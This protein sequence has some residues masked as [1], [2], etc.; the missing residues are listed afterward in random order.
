MVYTLSFSKIALKELGKINEPFY[1]NIKQAILNLTQN[2]RP[3]WL[4]E[5][6]R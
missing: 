5:V 3:N 1:S 2:P 4:Q 6:K